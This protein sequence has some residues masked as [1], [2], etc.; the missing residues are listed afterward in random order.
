MAPHRYFPHA[1]IYAADVK[2][3]RRFKQRHKPG[4]GVDK[5]NKRLWWCTHNKSMWG[6]PR[7]HLHLDTDATKPEH[8][9]RLSRA[10]PE[11]LDVIIDDGSHKFPD[12]EQT[13]HLLWPKLRP[14]G[15]YMYAPLRR[16]GVSHAPVT[17][18]LRVRRRRSI[19]DLLV[20][21]LPWDHYSGAK[22]SHGGAVPSANDPA[23]C[24]TECYYP[25]R[26]IE[27]PFMRSVAR[28]LE[29]LPPRHYY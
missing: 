16:H 28:G 22:T 26:L 10:L 7:L 11:Q 9:G 2:S 12:Q 19:E 25:Q 15:L 24:G 17:R 14:G 21:D 8:V 13:L 23:H 18:V 4:A 3:A 5:D 29:R 20:G 27:H 1:D 6:N